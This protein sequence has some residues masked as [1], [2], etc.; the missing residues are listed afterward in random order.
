MQKKSKIRILEL[1]S[2]L[3]LGS[4][5]PQFLF[6]NQVP[7]TGSPSNQL[8]LGSFSDSPK[9][10]L[11]RWAS[12]NSGHEGARDLKAALLGGVKQASD[13]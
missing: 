11:A 5:I 3:D 2:G 12:L 9:E 1:R 8:S 6:E 7:I 4:K 10:C 13:L